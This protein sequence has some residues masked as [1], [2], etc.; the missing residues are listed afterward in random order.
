LIAVAL[1]QHPDF[2]IP[3]IIRACGF[4]VC[5]FAFPTF[6]YARAAAKV[7]WQAQSGEPIEA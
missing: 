6:F 7:L 5:F 2:V 1:N 3:D 4:T